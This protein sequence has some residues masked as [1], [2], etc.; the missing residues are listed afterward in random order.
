MKGWR[1]IKVGDGREGWIE[2][3]AIEEI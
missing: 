2:T 3:K 1:G